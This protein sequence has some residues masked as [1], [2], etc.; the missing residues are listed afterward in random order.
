MNNQTGNLLVIDDDPAIRQALRAALGA[1]GFAVAEAATGEA[2]V[3][4]VANA[5]FDVVLL[6]LNM[7]GKGGMAA[8]KE[9]RA[10]A[11]SLQIVMLTVH[12]KEDDIVL[13]FEAGADDYVTK[14]FHMR[15]LTARIKA[16]VRRNRTLAEPAKVLSFGPIQMDVERRTVHKDQVLVHLTPKEFDLLHQ[17]ML[18][19]GVPVGHAKLLRTVWGP[20]YGGELEYLRT[21]IRQLR[22][23]IEND[24]SAPAFLLTAPFVGYRFSDA[25]QTPA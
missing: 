3:A 23:K 2:G 4:K 7:P 14:P 1:L 9:L 10:S 20:E 6:D 11:P 18:Q 8:C 17:L 24:P 22:I 15:E 5:Q 16:A 13:A 12:D 21:F 25:F 19:P